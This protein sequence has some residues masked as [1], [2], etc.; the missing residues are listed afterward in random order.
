MF[1]RRCL[2]QGRT[3]AAGFASGDGDLPAQLEP[4]F[5]QS[6]PFPSWTSLLA[7]GCP[8]HWTGRPQQPIPHTYLW[9]MGVAKDDA[10]DG[11]STPGT[12]SSSSGLDPIDAGKEVTVES[13]ALPLSSKA[14]ALDGPPAGGKAP[15][16]F[17]DGDAEAGCKQQ[18]PPARRWWQRR[19]RAEV[20]AERD[21]PYE[22]AARGQPPKFTKQPV[23]YLSFEWFTTVLWHVR[24][25]HRGL[26]WSGAG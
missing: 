5:V 15:A 3:E 7:S 13:V 14:L 18:P 11:T 1:C 10:A 6:Q 22:Y 4:A 26:L 20:Q 21:A 19:S 9:Q 16:A 23:L 24:R 25:K 8:V 2:P 12:T 17:E